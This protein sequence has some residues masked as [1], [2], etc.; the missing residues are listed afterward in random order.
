MRNRPLTFLM[1]IGGVALV[2]LVASAVWPLLAENNPG[3]QV[4]EKR[5]TGCHALAQ[6]REGPHLQGV[7]GRTSGSVAGFDYS[8]A[9][10]NARIVWSD[11]TL[12]RWLTDPDAYVSGNN[13]DFH[14]ANP[15][16]RADVIRFLQQQR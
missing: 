14:V 10:T 6:N 16:E 13:M 5:C 1:A 9:L 11:A 7:Y 15:Q 2:S 3:K 12:N 8:D 4:F